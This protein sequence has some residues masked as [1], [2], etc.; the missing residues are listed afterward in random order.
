MDR[1]S[2]AVLGCLAV[3][4]WSSRPHGRGISLAADL[5]WDLAAER[6][7]MF[8][9]RHLRSRRQLF[10]VRT[11]F[12][13][14]MTLNTAR[15]RETLEHAD[16]FYAAYHAAETFG[17]PSLYFHRRALETR[18]APASPQHLEY[19][20]ATLASW[21]MHRMGTGGS[22]MRTFEEFR[23]SVEPL[24]HQI[25]QAQGFGP[26]AMSEADWSTLSQ[27]FSG[28]KIMASSTS[29]VGN[30]KVMHHMLP[31]IV[32]IDREYTLRYLYGATTIANDV[33]KEW[34]MMRDK[35]FRPPRNCRRRC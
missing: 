25:A 13:A 2:R 1:E 30:S 35:T 23:A 6:G 24:E 12:G 16:S 21:G 27:I 22:K 33:D 9:S 7:P 31:N 34:R 14:I 5:R 26:G 29:L 10:I 28:L 32:P 17:G 3:P 18:H 8:S 19:V 20:Y 11:T 4:V 15:V